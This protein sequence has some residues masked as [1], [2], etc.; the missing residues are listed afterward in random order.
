MYR[1]EKYP[2]VLDRV[3]SLHFSALLSA[4]E[5]FLFGRHRKTSMMAGFS[6]ERGNTGRKPKEMK[7]L[8]A[9]LS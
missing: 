7:T 4:T 3:P 6:K 9:E 1:Q 5:S 2:L 8:P